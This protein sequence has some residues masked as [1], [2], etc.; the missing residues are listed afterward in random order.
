VR[1]NTPDPVPVVVLGRLAVD[2]RH[3][4]QGLG[5]ALMADAVRRVARAA[6]I[7]GVRALVVHAL[8]GA[9]GFYSGLGF[10]EAPPGSGRFVATVARLAASLAAAEATPRPNPT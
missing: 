3:Q 5:S 9:R 1:R 8:E 7:A 2:R 4:G 10:T 6:Q